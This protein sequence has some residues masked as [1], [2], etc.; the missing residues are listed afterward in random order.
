MGSGIG[1]APTCYCSLA[2]H[3]CCWCCRPPRPPPPPSPTLPAGGSVHWLLLAGCRAC[4][5]ARRPACGL[6]Q[7][8]S[9]HG[10]GKKVLAAGWSS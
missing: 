4:V 9:D 10:G 8:C 1:Y 2:T 7:G 6:R 5:A 3:R